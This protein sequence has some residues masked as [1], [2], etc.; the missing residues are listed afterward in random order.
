M[1]Q[2]RMQQSCPSGSVVNQQQEEM[3]RHQEIERRK[4]S[5]SIDD[6]VEAGER[7]SAR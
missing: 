4:K 5:W 6:I 7:K 2:R 1:S 3:E